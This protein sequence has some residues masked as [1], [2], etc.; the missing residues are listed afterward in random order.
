M[1]VGA[2]AQY[3]LCAHLKEL[4]GCLLPPSSTVSA[5]NA[6][7]ETFREMGGAETTISNG[8]EPRP[9]LINFFL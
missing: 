6:V 4:E 2:R 7:T 3:Y 9:P 8:R 5:S 1:G